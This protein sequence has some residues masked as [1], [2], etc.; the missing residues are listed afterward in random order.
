MRA[1]IPLH[2]VPGKL[3]DQHKWQQI[4]DLTSSETEALCSLN[5]PAPEGAADF[6]WKGSGS[7]ADA[8]RCY[9]IGKSLLE[10]CRLRFMKGTLVASGE[11]RNGVR[12]SIPADWWGA[13]YPVFA[14]DSIQGRTR[15]FTNVQVDDAA[16]SVATSEAR[17]N[18]CIAWMKQQKFEGISEKKVL[19]HKASHVF[20]TALTNRMFE[21]CYKAVFDRGRGRPFKSM[22]KKTN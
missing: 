18:D 19:W 8:R 3:L 11:N 1:P 16:D 15:Q 9:R 7:D 22:K 14:T 2:E 21:N 6:F 5:A 13:L 17:L 12:K 4:R 20:G 10:D